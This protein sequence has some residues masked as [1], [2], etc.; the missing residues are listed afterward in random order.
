MAARFLMPVTVSLF[1]VAGLIGTGP[2]AAQDAFP[3]KPIKIVLPLPA[4]SSLDIVA[5]LIGEQ[6]TARWK[7][8]VII[9]NKPGAN[10][11]LAAQAV[12]SAAPDGYTLLGGAA[13]IYTILPALKSGTPI[14][15]NKAFVPIAWMGGGPMY[16]A[17]SPKLGV[18]TFAE[19]AALAKSKPESLLVGTNGAG[20]L[21]HFA[22]VA[23]A[24]KANLPITVVP[25]ATG[26]TMDAIKDI[27]GGRVHATVETMSGL[28]GTVR[29]GD[30][31]PIAVMALQRS[32]HLPYLPTVAETVPGFSAV[33]WMVLS[34]PAGTP[35]AVLRRLNK[36]V[37]QALETPLVKKRYEEIGIETKPMSIR[38]AKTFV[39][40]EQ[41]LWWPI[42]KDV[43]AR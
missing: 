25:Y 28:L 20:T 42:V 18:N 5:R 15:V 16:I 37:Q 23:L 32:A 1:L 35:D 9:E 33:G 3:S 30:L 10:G 31:K 2:S 22:A 19:F 29:S 8:P 6:L 34:A 17:V 7:Q 4:G 11:L 43:E 38:E 24:K 21:P 14:D 27:L 12:A 39:A 36:G 41:A 26:G 40:S 13:F